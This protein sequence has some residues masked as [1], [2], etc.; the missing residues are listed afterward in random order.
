MWLLKPDF[1]LNFD[2]ENC[3]AAELIPHSAIRAEQ[4]VPGNLTVDS[5]GAYLRLARAQKFRLETLQVGAVLSGVKRTS[6]EGP[7]LS[8]LTHRDTLG[9]SFVAEPHQ[10]GP[11]SLAGLRA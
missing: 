1:A 7:K 3:L 10:R 4:F 2:D 8:L 6:R 5:A 9:R 11:A